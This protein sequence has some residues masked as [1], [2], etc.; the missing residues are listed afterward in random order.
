MEINDQRQGKTVQ[1]GQLLPEQLQDPVVLDDVELDE[2][3]IKNAI[4]QARLRKLD[5]L[6]D[7]RKR[8]LAEAKANDMRKP[9]SPNGLYKYCAGRATQMLRTQRG[10]LSVFEPTEF[11][12]PAITALSLYFSEHEEFEHLDHSE[13][14]ST[15]LPFDLDKGIWLWGN[16]GVGKTLIME[17]FNRNQRI[18]YD[19]VQCPKIVFGYMKS[20]ED[21]ILNYSRVQQVSKDPLSFYKPYKGICYNDLGVETTPAKYYGTPVNVMESIFMDTYEKKV[22]FWQRFVTTNL[23]LEQIKETYGVR[24][25]DRVKQSFNIIDIKGESLR[26]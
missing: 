6:E 12:K 19:V 20:G 17:M 24:F 25:Q 1:I 14:N 8:K 18:C 10:D 2:N 15:G 3:E 7:E 11:Q 9:W 21:H 5:R 4:Y 16:P 13:Y 22:P 23:T 26:K